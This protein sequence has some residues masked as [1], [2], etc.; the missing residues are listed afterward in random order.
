MPNSPY[1]EKPWC[2]WL[3]VRPEAICPSAWGWCRNPPAARK[4]T[5]KRTAWTNWTCCLCLPGS[6][7]GRYRTYI[8]HGIRKINCRYTHVIITDERATHSNSFVVRSALWLTSN[9]VM[10]CL[11][12]CEKN[13]LRSRY[14]CLSHAISQHQVCAHVI[15]GVRNRRFRF[16][17]SRPRERVLPVW[18][19]TAARRYRCTDNSTKTSSC[20]CR[21]LGWWAAPL[22]GQASRSSCTGGK[23][24]YTNHV[25]RSKYW[26]FTR[27]QWS[28]SRRRETIML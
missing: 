17:F 25:T 15:H 19:R 3:S 2:R 24:T 7:P 28:S 16:F 26:Q 1:W 4:R 5:W 13:T 23:T 27:W 11:M 12:I 6:V 9:Q 8:I 22:G 10:S 21:I 20:A 14:T 18:K